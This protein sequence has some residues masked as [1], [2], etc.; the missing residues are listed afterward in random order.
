MIYQ[1]RYLIPSLSHDT[2]T[3]IFAL[4]SN[5][6]LCLQCINVLKQHLFFLGVKR[7]CPDCISLLYP[8]MLW[9]TGYLESCTHGDVVDTTVAL[10]RWFLPLQVSLNMHLHIVVILRYHFLNIHIPMYG[11]CKLQTGAYL[12]FPSVWMPD[13]TGSVAAGVKIHTDCWMQE[14]AVNL[15]PLSKV[16]WLGYLRVAALSSQRWAVI[17]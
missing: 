7:S 1:C 2:A 3:V 9:V 6:M 4:R 10:P 16:Q 12:W 8:C 5:I 17:L 13:T 14:M 11:N 15:T